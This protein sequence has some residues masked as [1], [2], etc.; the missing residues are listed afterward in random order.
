MNHQFGE[1]EGFYKEQ[2]VRVYL[3]VQTFIVTV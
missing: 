1:L 3:Q 2:A